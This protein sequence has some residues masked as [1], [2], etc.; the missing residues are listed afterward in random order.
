MLSNGR[1]IRESQVDRFNAKYRDYLETMSEEGK[2]ILINKY[3]PN[4]KPDEELTIS[5]KDEENNMINSNK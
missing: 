5:D 2:N 4:T 3:F 1:E